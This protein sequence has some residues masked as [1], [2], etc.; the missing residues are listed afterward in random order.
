MTPPDLILPGSPLAAIDA[1]AR[2][3]FAD[4]VQTYL[5]TGQ[6][7]GSKSLAEQLSGREGLSFSAATIRN[8]MGELSQLGLL[9][10]DHISAGRRPTQ[11]GLRL[12][13][14]GLLEIGDLSKAERRQMEAQI[15]ASN[16]SPDDVLARASS[17][18][19]GLA[20]GAGL[21]LTPSMQNALRHVEFVGLDVDRALAV[22]VYADGQVENRIMNLPRGVLPAQLEQAGNYLSARLKGRTLDQSRTQILAEISDGRAAL[23][24]AAASLIKQGLADWSGDKKRSLIVRGRSRLLDNVQAQTDLERV[25]RLFEE[26]ERKEALIDLLDRTE[27][28]DGVKIFIGSE[29][30]L[31]ALSGSSMV[32]APYLGADAQI[33][34]AVAVIGPTRL[35]Y[36]RVIPM[37]DYTAQIVGRLLGR[38]KD[39]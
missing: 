38:P 21:V 19:S 10:K 17:L 18:L 14:D 22:L 7:V 28:A 20:G 5:A 36:A 16:Q 26:L 1:R 15:T 8:I 34:G 30:P 35:N 32:V 2:A 3:V 25:Q 23:D 37:V 29:N 24:S 27:T 4:L 9:G 39:E 6:A 33:I 11:H 31:F 13:V 12:F